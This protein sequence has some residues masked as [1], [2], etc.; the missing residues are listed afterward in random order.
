M[1][2]LIDCQRLNTSVNFIYNLEY[3]FNYHGCV[4]NYLGV[5]GL[6]STTRFRVS[7]TL[8]FS[9]VGAIVAIIGAATDGTTSHEIR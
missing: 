8:L 7:F 2:Y 4:I 1:S 9:A 6:I 5:L 3:F